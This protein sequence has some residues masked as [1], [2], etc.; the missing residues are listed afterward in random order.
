MTSPTSPSE[1]TH[2]ST[3]L[4]IHASNNAHVRSHFPDTGTSSTLRVDTR[5][6]QKKKT[7]S[8]PRTYT[9]TTRPPRAQDPTVPSAHLLLSSSAPHLRRPTQQGAGRRALTTAHPN[10]PAEAAPK[11]EAATRRNPRPRACPPRGACVCARPRALK[12]A[13]KKKKNKT[14]VRRALPRTRPRGGESRERRRLMAKIR[15]QPASKAAG[16]SDARPI[17]YK[18]RFWRHVVAFRVA[19]RFYGHSGV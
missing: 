1:L 12:I 10:P 19:D 8:L 14:P 3:S 15:K 11:P 17:R 16:R 5:L 9:H 13:M 6:T 4:R 7:R 18:T 2:I